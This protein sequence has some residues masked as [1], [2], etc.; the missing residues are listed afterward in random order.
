MPGT[1]VADSD[2]Q[3]RDR[4][5]FGIIGNILGLWRDLD[6]PDE[7]EL[8][9]N[10]EE[11]ISENGLIVDQIKYPKKPEIRVIGQH[12]YKNPKGYMKRGESGPKNL[13][14]HWNVRM[15]ILLQMSEAGA[16]ELIRAV[17][18]PFGIPYLGQSNCPAQVLVF[19]ASQKSE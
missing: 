7:M 8:A 15:E 2:F 4:A 13:V 5:V 16:N 9:P 11:W 10:L 14:Y 3:L 6:N 19:R 12:R 17:R 18:Q 1:D